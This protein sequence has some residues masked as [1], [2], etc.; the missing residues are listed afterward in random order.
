MLIEAGADVNI[1]NNL[2]FTA[3]IHASMWARKR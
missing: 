2:G 3:L 1:A